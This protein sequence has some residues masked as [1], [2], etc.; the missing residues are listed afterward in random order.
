METTLAKSSSKEAGQASLSAYIQLTKPT[1]S[2]LVVFTV[3]PSFIMASEALPSW[4]LLAWTLLGTFL[5]SSSAAVF[6]HLVDQDIDGTMSRTRKRP[7]PAG[8]VVSEWAVVFGL[9]LGVGSFTILAHQV[10]L[11]TA[12]IALA[13]NL[14]YVCVYTMWLKRW[15]VQNIVIGGAAGAVGPLIGAAAVSGSISLDAW[16]LFLV[17]FLWTPPHFW[18]LA[19]KYR[20]D[21]ARAEIP[22]LPSVKGVPAACNQI[23]AYTLVL[24]PVAASLTFLST[25]GWVYFGAAFLSSGYFCWL[26]FRLWRS[27]SEARAMPVFFFSLFYLFILFGALGMEQLFIRLV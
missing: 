22:M 9:V 1:I 7:L 24:L 10:N 27:Q 21:Y 6:N 20:K 26:A 5:A 19:I 15:T 16:V 25:A 3:V 13:A 4:G 23:F 12:L 11:L 17:I 14:F 8:R 18:A 2:L